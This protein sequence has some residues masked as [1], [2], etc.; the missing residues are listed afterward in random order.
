MPFKSESQRRKFA[1]LVKEGK[2]SQ[3]VFDSWNAETP[4]GKRLPEKA[5]Y[6]PK[7]KTRGVRK[8][9]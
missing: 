6:K 7:G 1:S 5:L 9:R 2:M 8:V 4:K 3:S